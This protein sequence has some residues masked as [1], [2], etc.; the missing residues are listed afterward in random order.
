MRLLS[1]MTLI[2]CLAGRSDS[3]RHHPALN[4]GATASQRWWCLQQRGITTHFVSKMTINDSNK[5]EGPLSP[6]Y[7]YPERYIT[8]QSDSTLKKYAFRSDVHNSLGFSRSNNTKSMLLTISKLDYDKNRVLLIWQAECVVDNQL[9]Y[10]QAAHQS[11]LGWSG[12]SPM[13]D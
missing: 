10:L 4:K 7:A 2:G 8:T 13:V 9:L 12:L 6:P 11:R 5:G 1:Q 3:I